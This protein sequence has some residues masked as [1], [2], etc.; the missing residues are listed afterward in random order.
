MSITILSPLEDARLWTARVL[1]ESPDPKKWFALGFCAWLSLLAGGGGGNF[2]WRADTFEEFG[3]LPELTPA[4]IVGI[5]AIVLVVLG[6]LVLLMWLA[7]RGT[8]MFL[9]GVARDQVGIGAAWNEYAREANSLFRWQLLLSGG[10][11]LLF[12]G[13]GLAW[14]WL[15]DGTVGAFGD[16]W[17]LA[18]AAG[19][20]FFGT[21][22]VFG[23][24]QF[25]IRELAVPIMYLRRSTLGPAWREAIGIVTRHPGSWILYILFRILVGLAVVVLTVLS[26]IFTCC[27]A[28]LPYIGTV[29]RLPIHVFVKS[30]N[31][32][33]ISQFGEGLE[34]F[35]ELGDAGVR[36]VAGVFE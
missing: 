12:L 31:L 19:L 36:D 23:L 9:D 14:F 25:V 5:V 16:R 18:L 35:A 3:S 26:M 30:Y 8:F 28:A 21:M 34:R 22:I 29:I 4:W 27:I 10:V 6:L 11:V 32:Y 1:F 13:I 2:N 17:P 24:V 7:S 15:V 20:F 33:F